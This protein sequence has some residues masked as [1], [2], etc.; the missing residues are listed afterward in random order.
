MPTDEP[1][2]RPPGRARSNPPLQRFYER[3]IELVL[4]ACGLLSIAITLAIAAVVLYGSF[5]FFTTEDGHWLD[6]GNILYRVW[7]FFTW[8]EWT[9]KFAD[10]HYGIWPLLTGTLL[11]VGIA[12]LVAV[13]AGLATA[14]YLSEYARPRVRALARPILELLAGIPTVIYG[15]F[16]VT[17]VT[18]LLALVVPGLGDPY[19]QISGGIV[20][21][22]MILPMI[23]A[24]SEN[25]LRAVPRSLRDGAYAL[26]A[27]QFETSVRVVLPAA[28]SG[29]GAA[30]LLALGRAVGETMA[31]TLACGDQPH[32]TLDPRQ[33][34]ATLTS[35]IVRLAR[36]D[37]QPGSTDFHSLFAIAALLFFFTLGLS[38]FAQKLLRRFRQVYP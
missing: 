4:L 6:A 29:I 2:V 24:L 7:Y 30:L 25:A 9:P 13:P 11:V 18:P 10:A 28:L 15:F 1:R 8:T 35:L 17:T 12:A 5:A 20:V 19:N 21:G 31:V 33:G 23:A 26:G 37:V 38:T 3:L 34:A 16:A 27:T 32:L 36:G 14:V 22:I